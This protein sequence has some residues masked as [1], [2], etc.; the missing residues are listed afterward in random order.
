M[1][2]LENLFQPKK[3]ELPEQKNSAEY[4]VSYKEG[5]GGIYTSVI[6]F[7]PW[8]ENPDKSI[9]QKYV[10]WLLD[11]IT[12]K[13]IYIDDPRTIGQPSPIN[14]MYW[15]FQNTKNKTFEEFGKKH[16]SS[17]LQYTSIIQII[18]DNQHPELVGQLKIF[19]FGK[20]IFDKIYQ[21]E[22]PTIGAGGNVFHPITGRYFSLYCCEQSNYNNFDRSQFI[23]NKD[24]NGQPLSTG[25][26][27]I[28]PKTG[29]YDI[30]S[31][32]TD[33]QELFNYL[34]SNSPSLKDYDY[35]PWTQDQ[36]NYVDNVLTTLSNYLNQGTIQQ[37]IA[38]VI[39]TNNNP[40]FP[41]SNQNPSPV[42]NN[43]YNSINT[44]VSNSGSQTQFLPNM[45]P[46]NNINTPINTM[47]STPSSGIVMGTNINDGTKMYQ[48]PGST[49]VTMPTPI[50]PNDM[51]NNQSAGNIGQFNS[52]IPDSFPNSSPGSN[53][54]NIGLNSVQNTIQGSGQISGIN[55]IPIPNVASGITTGNIN[56]FDNLDDVIANL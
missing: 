14:S 52:P 56:G 46:S 30:V 6:R 42:I 7:I 51:Q 4:K 31:E 33:H 10:S 44:P 35:N 45:I 9:M 37:N 50:I 38:T 28:N 41:G 25:M 12:Q 11:P 53:G 40:V 17:K 15:N 16:L 47:P 27:Y 2:N 34:Q 55:T 23:D 36:A 22:H 20:K 8:F 5:K 49:P 48:N 43:G 3:V 26:W 29:K 19:R 32:S 39:N 54:L 13:G 1:S 18:Q 21:E 24:Q